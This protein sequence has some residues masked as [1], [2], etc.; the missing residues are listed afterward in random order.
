MIEKVSCELNLQL[1]CQLH[2]THSSSQ[3]ENKWLEDE[4]EWMQ[5][6]SFKSLTC[7]WFWSLPIDA[8]QLCPPTTAMEKVFLSFGLWTLQ[9]L[10]S[11][12]LWTSVGAA[13]CVITY[14]HNRL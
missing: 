2:L 8:V 12:I 9:V 3:P 10:K 1:N 13:H 14:Q 6:E 7:M 5:R 11:L 4:Q